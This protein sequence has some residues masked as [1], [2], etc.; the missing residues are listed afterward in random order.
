MHDHATCS[1]DSWKT[2]QQSHLDAG[3]S[4]VLRKASRCSTVEL[5][6]CGWGIS[7]PP[8]FWCLS[9]LAPCSLSGDCVSWSGDCPDSASWFPLLHGEQ[10]SKTT[11]SA[12]PTAASGVLLCFPVVGKA[13][14]HTRHGKSP[15][16]TSRAEFTAPHRF[17]ACLDCKFSLWLPLSSLGAR[18]CTPLPVSVPSCA[19]TGGTGRRLAACLPHGA[20]LSRKRNFSLLHYPSV[21]PSGPCPLP[22]LSCLRSPKARPRLNFR[23]AHSPGPTI[24][25]LCFCLYPP[26]SSGSSAG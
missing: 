13:R 11:D 6:D 3:V 20:A 18:L 24:P 22:C 4:G 19:V 9:P 25:H 2:T 17:D 16:T 10:M 26:T 5:G 14:L 8:C 23:E 15:T 1:A 12:A 21:F 7:T